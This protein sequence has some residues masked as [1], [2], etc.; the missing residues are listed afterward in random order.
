M[1][2]KGVIKMKKNKEIKSDSELFN[3]GW[4]CAQTAMA[5]FYKDYY[6]NISLRI[7][8]LSLFGTSFKPDKYTAILRDGLKTSCKTEYEMRK[9]ST[10]QEEIPKYKIST[11]YSYLGVKLF[12]SNLRLVL[13]PSI[14]VFISQNK[15][16]QWVLTG[17]LETAYTLTYGDFICQHRVSYKDY[18][19]SN[20]TNSPY[21]IPYENCSE[22]FITSFFSS[23]L[24]DTLSGALNELE[25]SFEGL[26]KELEREKVYR[27]S[28]QKMHISLDP[29]L[30]I[31]ARIKN[32]EEQ[33]L[34]N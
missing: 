6:S 26:E 23:N 3:L 14:S 33:S 2:D 20:Y 19:G 22:A 13:T 18:V 25:K 29:L 8:G 31:L 9:S 10:S 27:R 16:K 32:F 30:T 12:A 1:N 7:S 15:D 17:E 5:N 4:S 34:C 24:N 11:E 28:D 21:T